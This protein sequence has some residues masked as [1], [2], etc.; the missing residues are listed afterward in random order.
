[1]NEVIILS[2]LHYPFQAID[3]DRK[4]IWKGYKG[5][6]KHHSLRE[7]CN[8]ENLW[9]DRYFATLGGKD[10]SDIDIYDSKSL[11]FLNTLPLPN[12]CVDVKWND[13]FSSFITTD[14]ISKL[15]CITLVETDDQN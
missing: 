7:Y 12:R 8:A 13:A 5:K 9:S 6:L 11:E 3:T 14:R 15:F 1:M 10:S 4:I 2:Y